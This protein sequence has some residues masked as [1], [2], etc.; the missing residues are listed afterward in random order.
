[1]RDKACLIMLLVGCVLAGCTQPPAGP[2]PAGDPLAEPPKAAAP[3]Q[4][5]F[6][7]KAR[8]PVRLELKRTDEGGRM[9]PISGGFRPT[10]VFAASGTRTTCGV[11][12]GDVGQFAPGDSHAVSLRCTDAVEVRGDSP[13]FSVLEEGREIGTGVVLP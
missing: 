6:A 4:T 11:D 13:G 9:S 1:M 12:R 3:P 2:T 7:P 8:I 5:S 10:M